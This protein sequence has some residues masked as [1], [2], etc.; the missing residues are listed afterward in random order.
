VITYL[1]HRHVAAAGRL[2]GIWVLY[3]ARAARA[4]EIERLAVGLLILSYIRVDAASK[5]GDVKCWREK[6]EVL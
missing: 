2:D 4:A 1:S 5:C 6:R 3:V